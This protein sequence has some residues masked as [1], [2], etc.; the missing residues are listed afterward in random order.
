MTVAPAAQASSAAASTRAAAAASGATVFAYR[1]TNP[2]DYGVVE[3]DATGHAVSLEEKPAKPRSNY[4]VAGLYFYDAQVVDIAAGLT[5][6]GRGELEITDVNREYLRRGQLNVEILGRGT[7]WL[8]TG[9]PDTLL[10]ASQFVQTVEQRQGLMV[11]APEEVA[12]RMGFI[13][14]GQL[15][16]LA[17]AQRNSP[18]G[19]YL[20]RLADEVDA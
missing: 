4:A 8:D 12:Y 9:T 7:A 14:V 1:V 5:P 13:D 17:S 2:A 10:Q 20:S 15:R 18:Y 16:A 6:S 3:F 11:S 19:A